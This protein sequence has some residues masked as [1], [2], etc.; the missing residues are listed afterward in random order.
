MSVFTW[1]SAGGKPFWPQNVSWTRRHN[2]RVMTSQLSGY[3]QT[4]AIPGSRWGLT[5]AFPAQTYAERRALEAWLDQL[6]G[7]EHRASIFDPAQPVPRGTINLSGV[8]VA[9]NAAQFATSLQL[10]GCGAATTLLAGDALQVTTAAGAQLLRVTADATA[11]GGGAMTV[12]F[13]QP[14]RSS[15]ASASAVVLD[16][17]RLLCILADPAFAVPYQPGNVAP[18]FAVEFLEV[19]A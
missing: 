9:A 5:L 6:G 15:V 10:N 17:P 4:L 19:F 1:P 7:Q 12:S 18:P 14:L 11:S 8:T 16:R 2:T 13:R 3:V